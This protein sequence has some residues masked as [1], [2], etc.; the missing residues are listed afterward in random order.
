VSVIPLRSETEQTVRHFPGRGTGRQGE[1]FLVL[2]TA[3]RS[4]NCNIWLQP[5]AESSLLLS[6][7]SF[8]GVSPGLTAVRLADGVLQNTAKRPAVCE[9]VEN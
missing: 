9:R 3:Y 8:Q 2:G 1:A 7:H 6:A 4:V 5:V